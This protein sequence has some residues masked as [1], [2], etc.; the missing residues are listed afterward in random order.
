MLCATV[1]AVTVRATRRQS[2]DQDHQRE[3]EQQV[4]EAE[5][6]VLDPEARD[7]WRRLPA[8]RRACDDERR[9]RRR[10]PLGLRRAAEAFD[11]HE[12]VGQVADRPSIAMA[13]PASPPLRRIVRRSV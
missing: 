4:I 7:R 9:L 5:Q 8:T 1:N 6:D 12:H 3:N 10:K 2:A 13:C 11:A